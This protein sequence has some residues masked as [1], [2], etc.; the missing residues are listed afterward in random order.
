MY[1]AKEG[2]ANRNMSG[3]NGCLAADG[4]GRH[5]RPPARHVELK[6]PASGQHTSAMI[7]L[8]A[9]LKRMGSAVKGRQDE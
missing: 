9:A 7:D 4:A 1:F 5:R 6:R 2:A 3:G 8:M